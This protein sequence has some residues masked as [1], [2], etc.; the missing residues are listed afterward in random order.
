M[1]K[2]QLE[3][4]IRRLNRHISRLNKV[5]KMGDALINDLLGH[6]GSEGFSRSTYELEDKYRWLRNKV[7]VL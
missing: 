6:D 5:I 3:A 4:E 7:N 2:D 1:T